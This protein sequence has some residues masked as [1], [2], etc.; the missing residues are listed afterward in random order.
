MAT[1]LIKFFQVGFKK[2]LFYYSRYLYAKELKMSDTPQ[3]AKL[4]T[5]KNKEILI[6]EGARDRFLYVIR[7]GSVRVY[8]TY[9]GRKLTLAILGKGEVFGEL[10]FFDGQP[11]IANVEGIDDGEVLIVDGELVQSDLETLPSWMPGVFKT[12]ISRLRE[13]D[14]KLT[15]LKN[16]YDMGSGA[17]D[18]DLIIREVITE[19]LRISKIFKLFFDDTR[20]TSGENLEMAIEDLRV[21]LGPTFLKVEKII[22]VFQK[23]GYITETGEGDK[24][25]L[26]VNIEETDGLI[27]YLEKKL[28]SNAIWLMSRSSLRF[29]SEVMD[30]IEKQSKN[31]TDNN[32]ITDIFE[33]PT[34]EKF[35][36]ADDFF[37][38]VKAFGL[39]DSNAI[40]IKVCEIN[41]HLKYQKLMANYNIRVD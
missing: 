37:K 11:R 27:K 8:K 3:K 20:A 5:F 4:M 34:L 22:L 28:S 18:N 40:K 36:N 35:I 10:S 2:V 23:D 33:I 7:S 13:T 14:N 30:Q 17:K 1:V 16:K 29:L 19:S 32:L 31:F 26:K 15:L 21:L 25:T 41:D 12:I 24:K 6:K 38:E 39:R 9:L